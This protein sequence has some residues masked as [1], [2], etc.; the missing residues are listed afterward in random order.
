[1]SDAPLLL[2]DAAR[3]DAG[4]AV[5]LDGVSCGSSAPELG[6]VGAWSPLF[7]LLGGQAT[8]A[9]GRAEIGGA[10]ARLAASSGRVGLAPR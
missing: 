7:A 5:L 3:I 9:S 4:G 8:L 10:P 2:L 6:L 1:M